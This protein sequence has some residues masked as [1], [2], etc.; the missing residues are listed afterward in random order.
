MG[1]KV[2]AVRHPMPYDPDLNKQKVQR[3]ATVADLK[4]HNC[5]IEEIWKSMNRTWLPKEM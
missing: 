2:V 4:K 3:F 1:L 5:T